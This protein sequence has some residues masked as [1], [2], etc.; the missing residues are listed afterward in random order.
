[1]EARKTDFTE[2]TR[3]LSSSKVKGGV[4]KMLLYMS[5]S[6]VR[7]AL[8][9]K[10]QM[11]RTAPFIFAL[12]VEGCS[13]GLFSCFFRPSLCRPHHNS[14]SESLGS[15]RLPTLEATFNTELSW[16]SVL[17][18]TMLVAISMYQRLHLLQPRVE[19]KVS[20][21]LSQCNT[22]DQQG[23]ISVMGE[24]HIASPGGTQAMAMHVRRGDACETL[25]ISMTN[26][27]SPRRCFPMS[28]YMRAAEVMR[29]LYGIE[30]ILLITD[31]PNV[32]S[33]VKRSRQA[34]KFEWQWLE[35]DRG[36]IG[37]DASQNLHKPKEKRVYIEHR[38]A[39][40]NPSNALQVESM[41]AD[42]RF[43]SE[44]SVVIGTS[45]S[46]VTHAIQMVM[47]ARSGVLPPVISLEGDPIY[48]LLHVRGKF[49]TRADKKRG[50]DRG[51]LP[52]PYARPNT[53]AN[54]FSCQNLTM[55]E[56]ATCL[57]DSF[58]AQALGLAPGS[59]SEWGEK[60]AALKDHV[61]Y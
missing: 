5:E 45:R 12:G 8:E 18:R 19:V 54:C 48:T 38:A 9:G 61:I 1:M 11:A 33:W 47:W 49:W 55:G 41:V 52:C 7:L 53:P 36:S 2:A 31:S 58:A 46:F 16:P 39:K 57:D 10:L 4:A 32:T 6:A 25:A 15:T 60:C 51:W 44:A 42:L 22:M 13:T 14:S 29:S 59:C 27:Y 20:Q 3:L 35:L 23:R 43:S 56:G 17:K 37:G 26:I 30:R 50:D 34:R 21:L 24:R 28:E 40:R